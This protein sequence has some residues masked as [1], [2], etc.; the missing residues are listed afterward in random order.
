M[1]QIHKIT[2]PSYFNYEA[3]AKECYQNFLSYLF[4]IWFFF[5]ILNFLCD[6]ITILTWILYHVFAGLSFT[7]YLSIAYAILIHYQI[8]PF[9]SFHIYLSDLFDF[10]INFFLHFWENSIHLD[11]P[12]CYLLGEIHAY[13][14]YRIILQY[15]NL[16]SIFNYLRMIL[17]YLLDLGLLFFDHPNIVCLSLVTIF[18]NC[19]LRLSPIFRFFYGIFDKLL[20]LYF[21][22]IR[23]FH[24]YFLKVAYQH[25]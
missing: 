3:E 6:A 7:S 19:L 12:H 21:W 22:S 9:N 2:M 1:H 13:F 25:K 14:Y 11:D 4:R 23:I 17:M 18:S 24:R 10:L 15:W 16:N 8:I 20:R 5:D